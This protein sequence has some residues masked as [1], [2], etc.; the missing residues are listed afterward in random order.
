MRCACADVASACITCT[1]MPPSSVSLWTQLATD[2]QWAQCFSK[3][4]FIA[5]VVQ[6]MESVP[7]NNTPC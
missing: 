6:V 7:V 2:A 5:L 4:G 1:A 3:V